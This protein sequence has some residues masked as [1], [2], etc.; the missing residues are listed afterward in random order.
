MQIA[1]LHL[2]YDADAVE[3][4]FTDRTICRESLATALRPRPIIRQWR[5][6]FT[7]GL[8]FARLP[9]G[10]IVAAELPVPGMSNAQLLAGRVIVYL[11]QNLWSRMAA[12]RHAHRAVEPS[13]AA[14]A[15]RLA[16]LVD[17]GRVVLPVS[18]S[19]FLETGR[20]QG[21]GRLPL[22]STLLELC[23]GWQ[24]R[25]PGV[26]GRRELG[27]AVTDRPKITSADVFTLES[28][29]TFLTPLEPPPRRFPEP[30]R[31]STSLLWSATV[32]TS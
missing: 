29:A 28:N 2:D 31:R 13:E 16:E 24:M 22:A 8:L 6:D 9:N 32:R 19:H 5:A 3:V 14:A 10:R 12:A 27:D 26:I 15:D 30:G 20:H 1:S 18:S 7:V 4:G 11:D 21:P 17:Q 25:H 23:R